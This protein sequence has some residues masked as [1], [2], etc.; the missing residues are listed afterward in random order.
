MRIPKIFRNFYFMFSLGFLVWMLFFDVNDL[1][2]QFTLTQKKNELEDQKEY[3]LQKIEEV[4]K[5]KEELLSQPYLLEK[6]AREKYLM[7][8]PNEDVFIVVRED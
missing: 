5:D 7:K 6:F 1:V 2:S 4:K 3:F 8:K